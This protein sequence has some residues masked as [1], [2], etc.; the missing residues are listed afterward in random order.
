MPPRIMG[1]V[2]LAGGAKYIRS[3]TRVALPVSLRSLT[4]SMGSKTIR[5]G[6]KNRSKDSGKTNQ[7]L[8]YSS[9]NC[10]RIVQTIKALLKLP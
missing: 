10:N 4:G 7:A 8:Q 6:S 3:R 2:S 5:E 9:G 1:M